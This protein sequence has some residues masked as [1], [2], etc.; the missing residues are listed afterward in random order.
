MMVIFIQ[1]ATYRAFCHEIIRF[2]ANEE[3]RCHAIN[4]VDISPFSSAVSVSLSLA[5]LLAAGAARC[6]SPSC[7]KEI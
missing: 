6:C 3:V 4:T 5:S 1:A 7:Y 2:R